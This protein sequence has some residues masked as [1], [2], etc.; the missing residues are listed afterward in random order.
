MM[1]VPFGDQPTHSHGEAKKRRGGHQLNGGTMP[2]ERTYRVLSL[3]A[4]IQSSTVFL[5]ACR[6]LLPKFD[7]AVFA[8]TQWEPPGV[9]EALEFL[10][11]EGERCG[12]PVHVVTNGS[13]REHTMEGV[14]RGSKGAGQRYATMPLRVLNPDGSDGMIRRQC[15]SE[16][17][18]VPI[19][20]F[21]RREVIGLKPRQ[22]IPKG[23]K[24][25]HYFGISLDEI[26]RMRESK[27][28]WEELYYPL[29]GWPHDYG[30]KMRRPQCEQWL[31][32]HY[33]DQ[34][35]QRSACIGCPFRSNHEW[36][37]IKADPDTWAD[38]VEVD[39]AIRHADGMGGEVFLHRSCKPL[40]EA[41]LRT[42]EELGQMEF[43]FREECTGYC[44]I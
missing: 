25:I 22:R 41:D 20:R 34:K 43:G 16:Y 12:I 18:I 40:T 21:I 37:D 19:E 9:Y 6:G 29:C 2:D 11:S 44:G 33:P 3:G 4:G 39:E 42:A 31:S 24:V 30:V 23:V 35:F 13:I 36:R 27:N 7:A 15:T 32:H 17:K 14:I 10:K 26:T 8:D 28:E 5:M 38:A 1:P